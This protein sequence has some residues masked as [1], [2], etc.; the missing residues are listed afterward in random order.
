M[1]P[2]GEPEAGLDS[3]EATALNIDLVRAPLDRGGTVSDL[4]RRRPHLRS[5]SPDQP[6]LDLARCVTSRHCGERFDAS[7]GPGA[8]HVGGERRADPVT[9]P[10]V[11]EWGPYKINVNAVAFGAINP[12]RGSQS[13]AYTVNAGGRQISL[14]IATGP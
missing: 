14:G 2:T 4:P 12:L 6:K 10:R 13:A 7:V 5:G 3:A 1:R 8:H 11:L 9:V